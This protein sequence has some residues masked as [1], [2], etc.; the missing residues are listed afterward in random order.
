MRYRRNAF[1]LLVLV[2][3]LAWGCSFDSTEPPN[4]PLGGEEPQNGRENP[5][6]VGDT[7]TLSN[8]SGVFSRSATIRL[9]LLGHISGSAALDTVM[10]GN[11][12]ND[13]PPIGFEYL[14]GRFAIEI[15]ALTDPFAPFDMWDGHWESVSGEGVEHPQPLVEV[16]CLAAGLEREGYLGASWEGW[17]PFLALPSD[18]DVLV[19]YQR[20][21]WFKL[22]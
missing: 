6:N 5:A 19:T 16:C 17:V 10:A 3:G 9:T 12:G 20:V 21:A 14:L 13:P 8:V 2:S 1:M 18:A 15:V 4:A 22:R 7:L 11:Q